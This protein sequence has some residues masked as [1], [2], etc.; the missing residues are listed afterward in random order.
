M[1]RPT[2]DDTA[3]QSLRVAV[4]HDYFARIGGAEAVTEAILELYPQATV[5]TLLTEE[6][7]DQLAQ[8]LAVARIRV[9][10]LQGLPLR[11]SLR[12]IYAPVFPLAVESFT[13]EDTDLL[14]TSSHAWSKG[15]L[16]PAHVCHIC[17]C[18]T[19]MRYAWFADDRGARLGWL[20]RPA[21]AAALHY[22]RLWDYS[23]AQRPDYFIA[24]SHTVR[25]RIAK[26]YGRDSRVVHP[27]VDTAFYHGLGSSPRSERLLVVSRLV[28]YKR[29][30]LAVEACRRLSRPLLVVGAGPQLRSLR[31]QAGPTI[32]FVPHRSRSELRDL[33]GT[34]RA[35]LLPGEEDFGI[36]PVEA[37]A[38]GMPV[39]AFGR[40]GARE[41]VI[42]GVTGVLF[43]APSADSLVD[44]LRKFDALAQLRQCPA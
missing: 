16:T 42:D 26:V 37:Q 15:A 39:I 30:D 4:F 11:W 17:Y 9:S 21:Q 12:P 5:S 35:L 14:I 7:L 43:D 38:C 29:I 3:T 6:R 34:C 2:S 32:T 40:G 41:T 1:E 31:R 13:F 24:N 10:F 33:Y 20:A 22:L 23:A 8:R 19:P 36:V 18:H 44:A 27:P 28:E 25:R